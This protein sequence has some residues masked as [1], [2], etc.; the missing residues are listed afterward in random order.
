M[1]YIYSGREQIQQYR[2]YLGQAGQ[3]LLTATGKV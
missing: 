3:R 2:L 1:T